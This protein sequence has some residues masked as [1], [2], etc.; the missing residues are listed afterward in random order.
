MVLV[1]GTTL[2]EGRGTTRPFELFGAPYINS[3]QFAD[4]L[5]GL[6][7]PGVYFRAAYFQ[8]TFQKWAR[9]MCGGVHLHVLDRETFEPYVTGVAAIAAAKALYP[10]SFAWREPPYEYEYKKL[11]IE[12]L[13]GGKGLPQLMEIGAKPPEIR[14]AWQKDVAR[15]LDQ[16]RPYLLY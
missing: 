1:E 13:C 5:N 8:P 11:P 2:S 9:T 16:R 6:G 14:A 7:L 12:I 15:F 4:H 10:E 3:R